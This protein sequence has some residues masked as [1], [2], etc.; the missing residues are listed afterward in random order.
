M[1]SDKPL[2]TTILYG[3]MLPLTVF[4]PFRSKRRV[5]LIDSEM[6]FDYSSNS[7]AF[8]GLGNWKGIIM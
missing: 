5:C 7:I 6:V 2:P 4:E 1:R 3:P 8:E